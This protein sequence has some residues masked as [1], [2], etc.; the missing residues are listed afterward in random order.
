MG[1]FKRFVNDGPPSPAPSTDSFSKIETGNL[2]T[3]TSP[4]HVYS[5]I[6]SR[7]FPLMRPK[8]SP[9]QPPTPPD[10]PEEEH[11][12]RL[13]RA[14]TV[15]ITKSQ[16]NVHRTISPQDEY[17]TMPVQR[18]EAA[19][20]RVNRSR[21]SLGLP[22]KNLDKTLRSPEVHPSGQQIERL[23]PHDRCSNEA[24]KK[25]DG[26]HRYISPIKLM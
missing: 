11:D 14:K 20:E 6:K 3:S 2:K 23:T 10:T 4:K 15:P 17:E 1:I 25:L 5:I 16:G 9:E 22:E 18:R 8:K 21:V 7:T 12:R 24:M 26:I 19:L 13:G